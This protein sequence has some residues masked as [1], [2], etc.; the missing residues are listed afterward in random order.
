MKL[1]IQRVS[2]AKL[3][4]DGK[5][6]SEINKG[7]LVLLGI[8][9]TDNGSQI[10][11]LAKKLVDLRI[12]ADENGKMNLSIKD[13]QGEILLVSQ[14]T[15][16]ASCQKGR[17]PDFN[18]AARPDIAEKLYLEFAEELKKNGIDPRLGIFRAHMNISLTNDGP[19]TIILER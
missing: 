15:L 8:S 4:V 14:F 10:E 5:I 18:N 7:M 16:Y 1:V 13:V 11:W 19:V 6:V 9:N 12:F 2:S 3:E 17:R